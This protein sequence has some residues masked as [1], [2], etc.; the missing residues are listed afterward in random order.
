MLKWT[1]IFLLLA[2][3][4]AGLALSGIAGEQSSILQIMFIVWLILFVITAI[5]Y[6]VEG[7]NS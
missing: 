2:V 5:D 7:F 6:T 4:T 1:L 3:V